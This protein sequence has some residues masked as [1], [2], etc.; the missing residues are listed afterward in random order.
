MVK[1]STHKLVVGLIC[2]LL[3][4]SRLGLGIELGLNETDSIGVP[5]TVVQMEF[6]P[7]A[8]LLFLREQPGTIHVYDVATKQE[9]NVEL[10]TEQFTDMDLTPDGRYLFVADY[11]GEHTGYGD[12]LRPHYVHRFDLQSRTW[13]I[14]QA[15][16]I[17]W[18]IEAVSG[19]RVLLQEHDQWIDVT[20]NSFGDFM[21]EL[22]R[23]SADYYGDIEYDPATQR[24]YHG[25]SGLSSAEIH[26][27]Q[28]DGDTLVH[29][30]E[31]GGYGSAQ[32]GGGT[33]VLSTGGRHF[34]YGRL[35]VEALSVTN[36]LFSFPERIYAASADIAFGQ[37]SYYDAATGALLGSLEF[38]TTVY[39]LSE[40]GHHLWAFNSQAK[41]LHRYAIGVSGIHKPIALKLEGQSA[42]GYYQSA[43][44]RA[45]A[46]YL[47]GSI[48]DVTDDCSWSLTPDIFGTVD[49]FGVATSLNRPGT[50]SLVAN[51][52]EDGTAVSGQKQILCIHGYGESDIVE[53]KRFSVG[54]DAFE[55]DYASAPNLLFIRE[56]GTRVLVVDAATRQIICTQWPTN[57]FT[58]MD[59]TAD[60]R[61]LFAADYGGEQTGY[62]D[63][64]RPHYVHRFD[65]QSRTWEIAQAPKIAWKI[66]AVSG[67][68]VLLQERDQWIDVTL[69]SFGDFMTELSRL[70]ADYYGDIEYDPATQRLY[71]GNSGSSSAEITVLQVDGDALVYVEGTGIYGSAQGGG[72][73]CVLSTGGAAFYYGKL[74]VDAMNITHNLLTFTD[75]IYAASPRIA[76]GESRYYDA[77][78]GA[79]L[80]GLGFSTK[81]YAVSGDGL[82]LWAFEAAGDVLHHYSLCSLNDI[83][84]DGTIDCLDGCE[85]DPAKTTPGVCGCGVADTDSDGD[86]VADCLDGCPHDADKTEAGTC[87]CGVPEID[88]DAD[89]TPDCIDECAN[90]PDKTQPGAC[91]CGIPDSDSDS[92]GVADCKDNCP[93]ALNP[94]QTDSDGNGIG[95]TCDTPLI[96]KAVSLK[97]HVS[98]GTLAIDLLGSPGWITEPRFGDLQTLEVTY[99]RDMF[100]AD[101]QL[102]DEVTVICGGDSAEPAL[103]LDGRVLTI[104]AL[105]SSPNCLKV[106]LNGLVDSDGAPTKHVGS[107]YVGIL[108][109]DAYGDRA[110]TTSDYIYIRG[111]IGRS[112][113]A[114]NCRADIDT[115]G[116]INAVDY[117]AVR[118]RISKCVTCP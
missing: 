70:S 90:D 58:D 61:Y 108:T 91:G 6:E 86:G 26:V 80:S 118:G 7:N 84:G 25:N 88:S 97:A 23:L 60:E 110:V 107:I 115:S 76:F 24:L 102:D 93:N 64:L 2:C 8:G 43:Q 87:G 75:R 49:A 53:Q 62:G 48:A 27:L 22:S 31:T 68:R 50:F 52:S 44:F 56:G 116:S 4:P 39:A 54:A 74:Q 29:V 51:Y 11:G 95:D 69:N 21:T 57:Q 46:S 73:T 28:V 1:V 109:G 38:A 41:L 92:G 55:I 33:S 96:L 85:L 78:S 16:K 82:H 37:N 94:D 114:N 40:D 17:A 77:L 14:A 71:H 111:R 104:Q 5:F 81:V 20:L 18:K 47:D 79:E 106:T 34:Y 67:D 19:V 112:A 12:P 101:A 42:I 32:G 36:N 9:I 3:A 99:S 45:I 65:L 66:E 83:D 35:Q 100:P 103:A 63:P 59:L 13:E 10:A 89:G 72:G 105:C 30:G 113:D 98:V 15:P 117:I